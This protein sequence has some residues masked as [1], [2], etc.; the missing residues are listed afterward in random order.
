M[1][2]NGFL[3]ITLQHSQ[4][5]GPHAGKQR[6]TDQDLEKFFNNIA[7]L[8]YYF[9]TGDNTM[10]FDSK[11]NASAP[12]KANSFTVSLKDQEG[13]GTE[14]DPL[15]Y[16]VDNDLNK[17]A[18]FVGTQAN[19][20]FGGVIANWKELKENVTENYEMQRGY[21]LL[22]EADTVDN[23]H[24]PIPAVSN[25]DVENIQ[26]S[27]GFFD[28]L[29]LLRAFEADGKTAKLEGAND[30]TEKK[31]PKIFTDRDIFMSTIPLDYDTKLSEGRASLAP[32][33]TSLFLGE[34]S[35]MG[36][37]DVAL[38]FRGWAELGLVTAGMTPIR[39]GNPKRPRGWATKATSRTATLEK[40]N[41]LELFMDQD[42]PEIGVDGAVL[43]K[44]EN[45][46]A[47]LLAKNCVFKEVIYGAGGMTAFYKMEQRQK[48]AMMN[49]RTISWATEI[50][51]QI[52]LD[53]QIV[54]F[55]PNQYTILAEMD[56]GI[57]VGTSTY[58]EKLPEGGV[59]INYF[60]RKAHGKL[61]TIRGYGGDK[62]Y[63]LVNRSDKNQMDGWVPDLIK[64]RFG[65]LK[66]NQ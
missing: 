14:A 47:P 41:W 12:T 58:V 49:S 24:I 63:V 60:L 48:D 42:G 55:E 8:L 23:L 17:N 61:G 56:G 22:D 31:T 15:T 18:G 26:L 4:G 21:Y 1:Y 33:G 28:E 53:A 59:N 64:V 43:P 39:G 32:Y 52:R 51:I 37:G 9:T 6:S 38:A 16:K 34:S 36:A 19:N 30:G 10:V 57:D 62:A 54:P 2:P 7:G 44:G 66:T 65:L 3:D 5:T 20:F 40:N 45:L 29:S 27:V 35:L 50:W 25:P 13:A 46:P 11:G